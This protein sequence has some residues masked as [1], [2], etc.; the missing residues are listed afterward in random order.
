MR[1]QDGQLIEKTIDTMSG[2]RNVFKPDDLED[3]DQSNYDFLEDIETPMES[4]PNV[5]KKSDIQ[6][7]EKVNMF[8]FFDFSFLRHGLFSYKPQFE[9][10]RV[11]LSHLKNI[12]KK[13]R[14]K[15]LIYFGFGYMGFITYYR[16]VLSRLMKFTGFLLMFHLSTIYSDLQINKYACNLISRYTYFYTNKFIRTIPHYPLGKLI[17][18]DID[19]NRMDIDPKLSEAIQNSKSKTY[20]DRK[21]YSSYK[22]ANEF[23]EDDAKYNFESVDEIYTL[24]K[25]KQ[26][27]VD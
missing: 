9:V 7:E 5:K 6:Q 22:I 25:G 19:Q 23:F 14:R 18:D 24:L 2:K 3:Y 10:E 15:N 12:S 11:V 1:D 27:L 8:K 20:Y 17:S 13:D 26:L 21:L 4:N 16:H